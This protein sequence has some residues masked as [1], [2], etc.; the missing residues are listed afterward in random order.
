M[1]NQKFA[2]YEFSVKFLFIQLSFASFCWN[3]LYTAFSI[4]SCDKYSDIVQAAICN[5]LFGVIR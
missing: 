1:K 5:I 4:I 3:M 2:I